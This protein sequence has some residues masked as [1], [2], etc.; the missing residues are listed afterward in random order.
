MLAERWN[1]SAW[2]IQSTPG[3]TGGQSYANLLEGVSCTSATAC[4]AVGYSAGPVPVT[5]AMRWNGTSWTLQP[6][7]DPTDAQSSDRQLE[8]VSCLSATACRAVGHS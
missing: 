3:L 6:T 4:T 7:A 1:G 2:A 8:G 5:L